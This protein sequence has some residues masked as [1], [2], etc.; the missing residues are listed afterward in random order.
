[1]SPQVTALKWRPQVFADMVGQE[2]ITRSLQN[3]M[4]A[5]RVAH[6]YIFAGPR[7]VGKTTTARIFAKALNC[8]NLKDGEPCN[9]CDMCMEVNQGSAM[10][11]IEIDSAS[12]NGVD[13]I[14]SLQEQVGTYPAKGKYK[15]YI[16]DEAHRITKQA[17]D[18]FLKT[19]EEPPA[20]VIFILASTEIHQF[21]A[22]VQSRCQR[23]EFRAMGMDTLIKQLR[24]ITNAEGIEIEDKGLYQIARAANGSMRDSQRTL[25]QVIAFSGKKVT[26]EDIRVALGTIEEDVYLK[27]VESA[28]NQDVPSALTVVKTIIEG[29]K[30]L[31]HFYGGLLE[32]F[33]HLAVAKA[34]PASAATFISLSA[35]DVQKIVA[36][37]AQMNEAQILSSLRLLIEQ[38][39]ALRH[40]ANPQIVLETVVLELSQLKGLTSVG[41]LL[42]QSE[43]GS[44]PVM[45]TPRPAAAAPR[46]APTAT[47]VS[48]PAPSQTNYQSAAP[49]PA[50]VS[51]GEP[52]LA[53]DEIEEPV[54]TDSSPEMA[55]LKSQWQEL[56]EKVGAKKVALK[57][58]LLDTRPKTIDADTLVL[59]CKG[60]FHFENLSKPE[61]K[62]LVESVIEELVGRKIN[63]VPVLPASAAKTPSDKPV[64]RAP[65]SLT[66]PKIDVKELE[67]EEPIV[68]AT[69][70]LFG[71]KVVEVKRNNPQK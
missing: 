58:V 19:L 43:N 30:D 8:R 21:P 60:P 25:D 1:M 33:R 6:A 24:R 46:P 71:A 9:T 41:D 40:S 50:S 2:H 65:K 7:G 4:K 55:K 61:N 70:K 66:A 64:V 3:A 36:F 12:F 14:R 51:E 23:F 47:P 49:K 15:I 44:A 56:L 54:E 67:K 48:A 20:H 22:T 69:M 27:L 57:G 68:A 28:V 59:L 26:L 63:L 16:F 13:D 29:G 53:V 62:V 32:T 38:E 39:W 10:D 31:E 5:E 17:F 52:V 11:V 45:A 18:A 42:K 34:Y 37:S 35:E